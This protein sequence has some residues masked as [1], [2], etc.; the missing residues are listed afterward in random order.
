ME[1]KE[2]VG[3]ETG[4]DRDVSTEALLDTLLMSWKTQT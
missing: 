4:F 2:I 3:D 1:V